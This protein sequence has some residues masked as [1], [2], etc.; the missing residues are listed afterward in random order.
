MIA[1]SN[2]LRYNMDTGVPDF[3]IGGLANMDAAIKNNLGKIEISD[4]VL[5]KLAG[6][7]A[8]ECMGVLGLASAES[9]TDLLR[10]ESV[11]RGVRIYPQDDRV[12]IEVNIIA[13][14]GVSITAVA[15]NVIACVKY[16][17]ETMTGLKVDSVDVCVRAIRV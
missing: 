7:A 15:E 8:T 12:R 10:K 3:E 4:G 6:L 17:V 1:I 14:Y 2:R 16:N 5:A 11:D 9:W 13:K